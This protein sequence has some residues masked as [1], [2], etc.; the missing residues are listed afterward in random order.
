MFPHQTLPHPHSPGL[1]SSVPSVT[2]LRMQESDPQIK[3]AESWGNAASG[4]TVC[5][6]RG[7]FFRSLS[8]GR[9]NSSTF[10]LSPYL[11]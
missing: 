7:L 5:A 4:A 1:Q 10:P 8:S 11:F 3:A 2:F 6:D 9:H